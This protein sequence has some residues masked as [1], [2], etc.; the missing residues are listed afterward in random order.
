MN[1]EFPFQI[2]DPSQHPC[3]SSLPGIFVE[4]MKGIAGLVD[5]FL[6]SRS[7]ALM[8]EKSDRKIQ[9]GNAG[10]LL[11]ETSGQYLKNLSIKCIY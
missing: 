5:A 11:N 4:A 9:P 3:L 1:L 8:H 6:G 10:R 7:T 2:S